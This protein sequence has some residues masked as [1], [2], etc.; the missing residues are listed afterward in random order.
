MK[1]IVPKL[2]AIDS[3]ES[4]KFTTRRITLGAG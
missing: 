1:Q 4:F 2:A 3:P